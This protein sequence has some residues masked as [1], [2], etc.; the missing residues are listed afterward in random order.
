MTI[1][2]SASPQPALVVGLGSPDRGDDAVGGHVAR[3][4]AAL[5]DTEVETLEHQDP[6]D[7]IELWVGREV[8]VVVD[9]VCSGAAA[10]TLHVL[11]TGAA[12]PPLPETAWTRTGRGGT[13]AFGLAAAVELARV[14]RRLPARVT[15]V[16]VEAESFEAG[17]PLSPAV[18]A[19]VPGAVAAVQE[20]VA[21]P[22]RAAAERGSAHVPG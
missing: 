10:G 15:V 1:S 9:A 3:A 22:A 13:H 6:T 14:L 20:A 12:H 2:T 4:V 11:Q 5:P 7:L 16:G 8:V 17:A 19:A 21:T 18:V